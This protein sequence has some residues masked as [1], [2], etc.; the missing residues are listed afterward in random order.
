MT[1]ELTMTGKSDTKPDLS[2]DTITK[3][4]GKS[5]WEAYFAVWIVREGYFKGVDVNGQTI[6]VQTLAAK[7]KQEGREA[8]GNRL[9]DLY[10]YL[11]TIEDG[12]KVWTEDCVLWKS[13]KEGY[14]TGKNADGVDVVV[15]TREAKEAL[16]GKRKP[17]QVKAIDL[18]AEEQQ[19]V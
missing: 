8:S 4:D 17:K 10:T 16:S 9:P 15:Q 12:E 1:E 3:L 2:A 5:I 14:F 18:D 19:E 13:K 6:I 7:L 11:E